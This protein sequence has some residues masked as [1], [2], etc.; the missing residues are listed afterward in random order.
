MYSVTEKV[1]L[2]MWELHLS[3]NH[4]ANH[5]SPQRPETESELNVMTSWQKVT[6]E[7]GCKIV[8]FLPLFIVNDA[9]VRTGMRN[10]GNPFNR[11]VRQ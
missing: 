3:A 11:F 8:G 5:Y 6:N 2:I 10:L 1:S 4:C 9:H 7:R